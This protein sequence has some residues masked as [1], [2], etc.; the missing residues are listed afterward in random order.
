M[1]TMLGNTTIKAIP[2]HFL[3]SEGNFQFYDVTR[4]ILFSGDLGASLVHH[5]VAA[6][7]VADFEVHI[8][9][10]LASISPI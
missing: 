4:K 6:Q 3:H 5:H 2:A 1:N 10:I 7:P 8:S 9:H